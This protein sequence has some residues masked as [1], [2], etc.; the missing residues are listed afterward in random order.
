VTN[1]LARLSAA[2][3][4]RYRI[5]RQLGQGGMATVYL[6]EDLRHRRRVAVKVL[7]PELAA[8]IGAERFLA[9]IRTT[10]NLQHPHILPLFDSGEVGGLLYYVMPYVS[11]E[12]LRTRLTREVQLPISEV[13]RLAHEIGGALDYA[14][15]Q[16]VIHRDIKPE[17]ILLQDGTALVADF[18]IALA[19]S[20][21]GGSRLTQTGLSLGT[22]GYMSPEQAAGDRTVDARCD[23]YALGAVC[24]EMLTGQPPFIAASTQALIAKLMTETPA[25][26]SASRKSVPPEMDGAILAALEKL[27]ADRP[28]T[29][30]E[31]VSQLEAR[32]TRPQTAAR[33]RS[34]SS[35]ILPHG[36]PVWWLAFAA[37]LLVGM[38]GTA[39]WLPR[40]ISRAEDRRG[41]ITFTGRAFSPAISPD[42]EFVAY[43]DLT[44]K[45]AQLGVC[46]SALLLQEAGTNQP[47]T[48]L[49]NALEL[50]QLRWAHDGATLLF[51]GDLDSARSGI[52]AIPRLGGSPRAIAPLA[53]F[54][55]HPSGDTIVVVQPHRDSSALARIIRLQD[56]TVVDSIA[57]PFGRVVDVAWRPDGRH[58]AWV[59][60]FSIRVTTRHGDL[61]ATIPIT[62]RRHVRWN[63]TGDALL[64]FN[65]GVGREDELMRIGIDR[66]GRAIGAPEVALARVPTLYRGEFDVARRSGR[67]ILATGTSMVDLWLFQREAGGIAGQPITHGSTWYGRPGLSPDGRTL[68]YLRGD[69]LGDNLYQL[70]AESG[71]EEPL[72]S[73]RLPG[74]NA[75]R[76]S[77]DGRR[78]IYE[79]Q[80]QGAAQLEE[81]ELPSRRV[82]SQQPT[83][84]RTRAGPIGARGILGLTADSGLAL[85][86]SITAPAW[87][88]LI[89]G[90]S[91]SVIDFAPAPDGNE[92]AI[93]ASVHH[94]R[95][96]LAM[97]Q[98]ESRAVRLV[99]GPNGDVVNGR[100]TWDNDGKLYF[101]RW[102]PGDAGPSVWV[103]GAAGGLS[104]YSTLSAPC[105]PA[106]LIVAGNG[107]VAAC[108]VND[109]R[110][111]IW[112][113]DG[114]ASLGSGARR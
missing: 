35:L 9:E 67:L 5:E 1:M 43:V 112:T 113:I 3:A 25:A 70:R 103:V 101:S 79:H 85:L 106:S 34:R 68:Y 58:L 61:T 72:T 96:I 12:S 4:D 66:A 86:D 110:S 105:E 17:N 71:V 84:Q 41:Q 81:M 80:L 14:H 40:K 91:L 78:L 98:V 18:G 59:S 75:V 23:V 114:L 54:D 37:G 56:G 55:S 15:R 74:V 99:R 51:D 44:C 63:P 69:A 10:A 57:L 89:G 93:L 109:D 2:L 52:F 47:V 83:P 82:V 90:D 104:R 13:V 11:G 24:Y 22:P 39:W 100:L 53:S 97:L 62:N 32:T 26:P 73:Q 8:V 92:I 102:L 77:S 19:V 65:A 76:V 64:V 87:R 46:R 111:D 28:G 30:A 45:L 108:V 49:S 36:K 42:G 107:Q 29:P 20:N 38:F 48:L 95:L 27:P 60:D 33:A 21:A 31:F 94:S 6:A 16:G 7:R 88:K 50:D